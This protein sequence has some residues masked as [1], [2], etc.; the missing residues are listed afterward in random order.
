MALTL[1]QAIARIPF[2]KD[3]RGIRTTELKGGITNRN[4]KV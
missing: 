4:Y 1:E 3:A 2:L